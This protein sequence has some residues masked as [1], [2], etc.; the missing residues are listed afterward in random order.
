MNESTPDHVPSSN[1][2]LK[3]R[4]L[5]FESLE[6][7]RRR[8]DVVIAVFDETF[9]GDVHRHLPDA[10]IRIIRTIREFLDSP[11]P[12]AEALLINAEAG[13]AWTIT[14]PEYSVVMPRDIP[15]S[16]P[17][18]YALPRDDDDF[19]QFINHWI[20]IHRRDGTMERL[21][22]HWILGR[23]DRFRPPRWSIIRDVLGWVS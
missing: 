2:Q 21:Y 18:V 20:E 9:A 4:R 23:Q 7:I 6:R 13:S 10:E 17:L 3:R 8:S 22:D 19:E 12:M 1:P 5:S 14:Y 11:E 15:Q 16:V